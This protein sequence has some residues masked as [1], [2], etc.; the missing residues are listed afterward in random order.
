MAWTL[1]GHVAE[2]LIGY[3]S[4]GEVWRGRTASGE[5]VALKRVTLRDEGQR[6]AARA[7][8]ALLGALEHPNLVRLR[9]L[10]AAPDAVVLVL[11][12][13][14]GGSLAELLARRGALSVGEAV[15][16]LAPIGAALA[17]AHHRDVIHGDVTPANVLFSG[18]GRP[19][20]SDL[21]V[22][23][24]MGDLAAARS[25]PAYLD[26]SVAV[27][28]APSPASDVFMLAATALHALTGA[29]A[30]IGAD[31][32]EVLARA[33]AGNLRE[34][35]ERLSALP[36]WAADVL[37]R[38][39][40]AEP[41]QRCTAAEFVLDLAANARAA[42]VEVADGRAQAGRR[43][44]AAPDRSGGGRPR[45][46]PYRATHRMPPEAANGDGSGRTAEPGA[47][48]AEPGGPEQLPTRAVR[49]A[50]G[51]PSDPLRRPDALRL[52]WSWRGRWRRA[53]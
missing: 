24:L 11:D 13:A 32:D 27:G 4:A 42:L 50:L 25:A 20:L 23:R 7:E 19:L 15:A 1:P 34:L 16:V 8:A 41:W 43:P 10:V 29:P 52:G 6:F 14:E 17:Y 30:W 53:G 39:L 35:E 36:D 12:L 48:Q 38:G 5:V 40:V 47:G 31:P 49:A 21:G 26:P 51:V 44:P 33:A 45:S 3:G 18:S 28:C 2:E 37:R 9:E 22:A 46:T